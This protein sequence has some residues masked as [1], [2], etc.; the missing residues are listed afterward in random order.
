MVNDSTLMELLSL[1][2]YT[3]IQYR[4][5]DATFETESRVLTLI[6]S[7]GGGAVM[8][9]DGVELS[10]DSALVFDD[11]T[12]RLVSFG[13]QATFTPEDGNEVLT[14]Q[15]IFDLNERRGTALDAQ[16]TTN[17]RQGSWNVRGDCP[18]SMV[19]CHTATA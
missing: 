16:T 10:A 2:G 19:T 8:N 12:G 13:Q 17:V 3:L 4:S 1:P 18:G 5:D 7:G 9:R 15:I 6:S 14:R 11:N